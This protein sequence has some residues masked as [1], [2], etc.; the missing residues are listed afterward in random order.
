[1]LS[2]S[3]A[4]KVKVVPLFV[5]S[6]FNQQLLHDIVSNPVARARSIEMMLE[7]A[8]KYGLDG[9]QFDLEGLSIRDK[10][11]FTA[12]FRETATAVINFLS[13]IINRVCQKLREKRARCS[14]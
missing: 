4:N 2:P 3:K 8:K 11:L 13:C 12:Y 7:Y 1:M 10:D 9:W 6:G 5:N 14:T